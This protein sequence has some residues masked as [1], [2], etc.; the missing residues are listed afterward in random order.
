MVGHRESDGGR[1]DGAGVGRYFEG[2]STPVVV[3]T[4][5]GMMQSPHGITPPY[6]LHL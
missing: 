2:T 3:K 1:R 4:V 6:E 5:V